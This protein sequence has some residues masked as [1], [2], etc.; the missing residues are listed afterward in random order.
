[1][2]KIRN[3]LGYKTELIK[4]YNTMGCFSWFT[5]DKSHKRI[6]IG[7]PTKPI[8]MIGKINGVTFTYTQTEPYGG[9]GVF[10]GKDYYEFMAEMNGKTLADFDGNANKLRDAGIDMAFD[11]DKRGYSV[12]WQHPTLTMVEGDYHNGNAPKV[13]PDQGF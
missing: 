5:Q 8:Y 10:G 3:K 7:K 6:R 13:D 2:E 4:N 1:M 11:G 9:Y 12:K